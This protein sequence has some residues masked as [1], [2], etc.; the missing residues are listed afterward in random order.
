MS[1]IPA[2]SASLIVNIDR[3]L[4]RN[5][6]LAIVGI[7]AGS[8]EP[9]ATVD[10]VKLTA[11]VICPECGSSDNWEEDAYRFT[12]QPVV[13]LRRDGSGDDYSSFDYG[14]DVHVVGWN[15]DC[16]FTVGG[17]T[18]ALQM[19]LAEAGQRAHAA[20]AKLKAAPD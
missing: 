6:L 12:W 18:L 14:D 2:P 19:A 7:G 5:V 16:G 3:R 15:C 10:L 11:P 13:G 9:P 20:L 8:P 1:N 4:P 17:D